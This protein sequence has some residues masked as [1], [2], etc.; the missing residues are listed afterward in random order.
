MERA[1]ATGVRDVLSHE[2]RQPATLAA[3]AIAVVGGNCRL[4]RECSLYDDLSPGVDRST[5][6]TCAGSCMPPL[7][8]TGS[9]LTTRAACAH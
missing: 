4:T 9:P 7:A 2:A 3:L 1:S 8:T 5:R 6:A